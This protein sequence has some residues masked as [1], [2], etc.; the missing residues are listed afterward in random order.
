MAILDGIFADVKR[1]KD[2]SPVRV[3]DF[4]V[5]S[6]FTVVKLSDGSIGSAGNYDVQNHTAD[7]KP[8]LVK[9]KYGT[10]IKNDPLLLETLRYDRSLVGLSL[11]T[12]IL[13]ALSQDLLNSST[14]SIF[15]LGCKHTN[16]RHGI[17]RRYLQPWDTIAL[18]GF[19]GA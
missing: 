7:Y 19:G 8:A 14:L 10:H 5:K 1:L 16:N 2:I 4:Y 18:I 17:L 9:E 12:A 13:S 15:G 11:R 3:I 6:P